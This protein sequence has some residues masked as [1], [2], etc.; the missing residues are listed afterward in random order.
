MEI[1]DLNHV[2]L[3]VQD[4]EES[5][6]FYGEILDLPRMARPAFTFP[7]AWFQIGPVQQLHLIGER[8]APVIVEPRGNHFAVRV[9]SIRAA[10]AD[11][12]DKQVNFSGPKQR[13][14]GMWQ[15]FLR[16]PDGHVVELTEL[17]D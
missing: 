7:G 2:A 13:P 1:L 17:P 9:K 12:Q 3:H 15:I 8:T 14:D 10:E 4:V 6:R 11:L 16:D 5:C